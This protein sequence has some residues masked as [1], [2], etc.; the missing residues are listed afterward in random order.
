[1]EIKTFG[2]I[3]VTERN[4][5]PHIEIRDFEVDKGTGAQLTLFAIKYA[6][7]ALRKCIPWRFRWLVW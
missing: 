2:K 1:M 3:I 5:K 4:G 6:I 7:R